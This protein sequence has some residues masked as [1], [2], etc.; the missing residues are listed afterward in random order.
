M[1]YEMNSMQAVIKEISRDISAQKEKLILD[2]L[3]ELVKSGVLVVEQGPE[4]IVQESDIGSFDR[5]PKFV[6]RS[7]VRFKLR[8]E[9]VL[10]ELREENS[11]LR[12]RLKAIAGAME[13]IR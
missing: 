6:L 9:E 3:G 10:K 5:V 4:M 11:R 13:G 2:Q 8:N 12:E 7:Q 1:S